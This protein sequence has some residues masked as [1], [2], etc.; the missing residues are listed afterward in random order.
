MKIS[1]KLWCL[2]C[3]KRFTRVVNDLRP[4]LCDKCLAEQDMKVEAEKENT[5]YKKG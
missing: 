2:N 1:N 4:R 5:V 3:K